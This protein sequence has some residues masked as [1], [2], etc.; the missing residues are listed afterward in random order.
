MCYEKLV[1][2]DLA[3][4]VIHLLVFMIVNFQFLMLVT[5]WIIRVPR[6]VLHFMVYWKKGTSSEPKDEALVWVTR[7][8][9]FRKWSSFA[10]FPIALCF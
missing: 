7:E 8:L 10:Y 3:L 4:M 2:I 6:L 5:F 1:K 9:T